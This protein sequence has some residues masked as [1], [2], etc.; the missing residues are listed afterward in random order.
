MKNRQKR[1]KEEIRGIEP[2]RRPVVGE[3]SGF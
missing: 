1:K 2:E 3:F